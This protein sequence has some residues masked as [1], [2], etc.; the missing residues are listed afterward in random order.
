MTSLLQDPVAHWLVVAGAVATVVGEV[1][2]T[3]LGQAR[4]G[5]RGLLGSLA[6]SLGL[7]MRRRAAA[8]RQGT[9]T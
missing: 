3:Y 2:A 7:Y 5:G 8:F 6:D 9:S 4:D 1:G